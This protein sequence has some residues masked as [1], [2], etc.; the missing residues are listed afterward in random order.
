MY[1]ILQA[2][3]PRLKMMDTKVHLKGSFT[4]S[5]CNCENYVDK[6]MFIQNLHAEHQKKS[7]ITISSAITITVGEWALII[8]N[9]QFTQ[10]IIINSNANAS[11]LCEWAIKTV[12]TF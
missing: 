9:V 10:N 3:L 12:Q 4:Y 6:I 11:A 1:I 8:L 5:D 2:S 7:D